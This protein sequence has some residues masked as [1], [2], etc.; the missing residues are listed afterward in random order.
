MLPDLRL[1][2]GSVVGVDVELGKT[3]AD[4]TQQ[5]VERYAYIGSQPEGQISKVRSSLVDMA[6][7]AALRGA[8]A[9]A[10]SPSWSG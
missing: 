9:R 6:V 3:N 5:L 1:E 7:A 8:R 10:S 4:N 2:S